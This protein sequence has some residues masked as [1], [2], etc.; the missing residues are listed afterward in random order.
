MHVV[1][2][3]VFGL[4]LIVLYYASFSA[5]FLPCRIFPICLFLF[6][7]VQNW[8]CASCNMQVFFACIVF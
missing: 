4:F 5:H 8:R 6:F 7:V 1:L 2:F 3:V